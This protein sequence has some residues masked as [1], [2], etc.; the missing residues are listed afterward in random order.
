MSFL[1]RVRVSLVIPLHAVR[2]KPRGRMRIDILWFAGRMQVFSS[3]GLRL[4]LR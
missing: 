1:D 4:G 2:F 3:N